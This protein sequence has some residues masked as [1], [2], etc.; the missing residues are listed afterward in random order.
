MVYP[1]VQNVDSTLEQAIYNT[2]TASRQPS[3]PAR[4]QISAKF[5]SIAVDRPAV[6]TNR[7]AL[8]LNV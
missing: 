7:K 4:F 6:F 8:S 5:S 1:E 3:L 2:I